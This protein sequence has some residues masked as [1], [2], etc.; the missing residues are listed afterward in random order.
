MNIEK[1]HLTHFRNFENL[2]I[3]FDKNVTVIL[4]MNGQ[5]KT[6]ILEAIH[7]LSTSR[8]F[9]VKDDRN[10]IQFNQTMSRI[11]GIFSVSNVMKQLRVIL[12]LDGKYLLEN[13]KTFSTSKEFVGIVNTLLFSPNDLFLF[14]GS[15]KQRRKL[16]DVE[17]SK[18]YPEYIDA[19]YTY[20]KLLKERNAHLKQHFIDKDYISTL[21][22]QII[23][24]SLVILKLRYQFVN[25]LNKMLPQLYLKLINEYS[26]NVKISLET[27]VSEVSCDKEHVMNLYKEALSKDILFKSTQIGVH[28]DDLVVTINE[29]NITQVASQGQKRMMIIAIK[30][31]LMYY[32]KEKIGEHPILLLDDVFSEID[33]PKRR[34][35]IEFL[36]KNCQTIVTTTDKTHI[37]LW[38]KKRF[39][40]LSLIGGKITK[41]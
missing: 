29:L 24:C 18:L 15:P 35:F 20:N 21:D 5:G 19:L 32:I 28:K 38:D 31:C 11:V 10:C 8:S 26:W 13:N 22:I 37:N 12:S 23:D 3:E 40:L 4:G 6:N 25:Y 33:E 2:H 39:T 41:E 14:D 36:P 9:R 1:L 34:Q 30:L 16:I 27:I 7:Y 17:L